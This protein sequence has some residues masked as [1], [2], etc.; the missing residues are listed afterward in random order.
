MVKTKNSHEIRHYEYND[1]ITILVN[2]CGTNSGVASGYAKIVLDI[3]DLDN[4]GAEDIL[5]VDQ[6][7]LLII[8]ALKIANGIIVSRG[9][10][11]SRLAIISR[12]LGIPCIIGAEKATEK[13][14]DKEKVI[15][16]SNK[17]IAFQMYLPQRG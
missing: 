6:S 7:T 2:G 11:N 10:I 15:L 4:I 3:T 9:G 16:D 17:G 5:V 13:L 12:E 14:V 8:P 1:A